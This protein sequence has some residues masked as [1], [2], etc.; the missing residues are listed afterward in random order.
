MLHI[1]QSKGAA[2]RKNMKTESFLF[3]G[4]LDPIGSQYI[5]AISVIVC[6]YMSSHVQNHI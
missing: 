5:R 4:L 2:L 3:A 6:M 1:W